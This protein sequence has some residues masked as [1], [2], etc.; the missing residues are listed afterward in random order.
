MNHILLPKTFVDCLKETF[1][2]VTEGKVVYYSKEVEK[3]LPTLKEGLDQSEL[4]VLLEEMEAM[5]VRSSEDDDTEGAGYCYHT[6]EEDQ[7]CF[8]I[9]EP[10]KVVEESVEVLLRAM[11]EQLQVL[12]NAM[13]LVVGNVEVELNKALF[14]RAMC[15]VKMLQRNQRLQECNYV[16]KKERVD[17]LRELRALERE[18]NGLDEAG[19]SFTVK[20]KENYANTMG[21]A[22]T[23]RTLFMM[24]ISCGNGEIIAEVETKN[25][26]IS[27]VIHHFG[28]IQDELLIL[29]NVYVFLKALNGTMITFEERGPKKYYISFPRARLD[30]GFKQVEKP[31]DTAAEWVFDRIYGLHGDELGYPGLLLE[32]SNILSLK[33]Y[34][35]QFLD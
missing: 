24:M 28:E 5:R 29:P 7:H 10:V 16:C 4:L 23:L 21:E 15:R 32:L 9:I 6:L 11:Q 13:E 17:L 20:T 1:V 14:Q 22:R 19:L 18:V 26:S 34:Y 12:D 33:Q 30:K 25:S 8:Y 27:V 3:I 31:D 35:E 2:L